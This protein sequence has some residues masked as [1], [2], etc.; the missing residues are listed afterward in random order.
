MSSA[1][2]DKDLG[3]YDS[4]T[5]MENDFC[6]AIARY[7]TAKTANSLTAMSRMTI[8]KAQARLWSLIY[9]DI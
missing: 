1:T 2:P 5:L 9:F 3:E 7:K 4:M 8:F 6:T